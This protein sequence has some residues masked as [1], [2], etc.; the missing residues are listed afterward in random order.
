MLFE[1]SNIFKKLAG[2]CNKNCRF[3]QIGPATTTAMYFAP[4]YDKEGN[5]LNPDRNTTT[6]SYQCIE[7]GKIWKVSSN[8]QDVKILNEEPQK[9]FDIECLK[10]HY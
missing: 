4:V 9:D 6:V 8:N 1:N 2:D 10:D 7:C 3:Q 5:N